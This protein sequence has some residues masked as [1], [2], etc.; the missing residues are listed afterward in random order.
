MVSDGEASRWHPPGDGGVVVAGGGLAAQRCAETLRSRGY[1]GPIRIVCGEATAPYDRPPLSKSFL[2]APS[3]PAD[4]CFRPDAWHAENGIELLLGERACSIDIERQVLGLES[5]EAVPY[6]AALIA[7]GSRPRTLPG[8]ARFTNAHTLRTIDDA[9]RLRDDLQKGGPVVIIG[10]GFVGLEVAAAARSLGL[11]V[12]VVEAAPAPLMRV[13]GPQLGGWF[14]DLHRAEGVGFAFDARITG[15]A[16]SGELVEAVE[17]EG[18]QRLECG[19]LLVGVGIEPDTE[20]LE[21]SGFDPDGV[22][23][24]A[25]GRT[26]APNV[27]AAG[28]AAMLYDRAAGDYVRSEHWEAAA[29]EGVQAA[30]SM[31]QLEPARRRMSS[32][33]T[34]Q[35]GI[36][37]QTLGDT[38]SGEAVEIDGDP[39]E[40][41]F[42]AVVSRDGRPVGGLIAGRPRALPELRRLIEA[43][44]AAVNDEEEES[45]GVL[46]QN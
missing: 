3:D 6:D 31:L 17:L 19:V 12:T 24:D 30:R 14:V 9:A 2:T 8:L 32:F 13:I 15:F 45:D 41:E 36:R 25:L 29:A 18:G 11:D 10:A 7:T 39:G 35:Y 40:R 42:T 1:E 23:A 38:R 16:G 43:S 20:W 28:D 33:W 5:G 37:I 44:A 21:A 27:Y 4:L 34:D 46:A 26:V 22:R